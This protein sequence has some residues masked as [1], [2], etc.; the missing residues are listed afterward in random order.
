MV[1]GSARGQHRVDLDRHDPAATSEQ[2]QGQRPEPGPDLDDHVVG[3]DAGGAHDAAHGVGVDDEVLPAL[4]GG[5][6]V[7]LVGEQ[8]HLR[9]PEE[10]RTGGGVGRA[11]GRLTRGDAY[12]PVVRRRRAA[13]PARRRSRRWRRGPC[14]AIGDL[15]LAAVSGREAGAAVRLPGA[16]VELQPAVVAVAGVGGPVAAGL[17]RGD[18]VPDAAAAGEVRVGAGAGAGRSL[19]P[20]ATI[21]GD[22]LA[23]ARAGAATLRAAR[24][25]LRKTIR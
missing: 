5:P 2:R 12:R 18:P 17:A 9:R 23:D 24:W 4:L 21:C 7:E 10:P 15:R 19:V 22:R 13:A 8:T 25:P 16:E 14:S 20:T 11:S 1:A 3:A 6:Q